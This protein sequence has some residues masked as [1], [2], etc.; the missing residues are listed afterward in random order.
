MILLHLGQYSTPFTKNSQQ[1]LIAVNAAPT[2]SVL[3]CV[4]STREELRRCTACRHP[5]CLLGIPVN[6]TSC[7]PNDSNRTFAEL[8][9]QAATG[10]DH[11]TKQTPTG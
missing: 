3:S 10:K 1:A 7:L 6:L 5:K 9:K 11:K 2:L 4:T 8:G